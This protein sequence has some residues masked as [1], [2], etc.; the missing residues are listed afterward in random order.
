MAKSLHEQIEWWKR[1]HCLTGPGC[2]LESEVPG[3]ID[4]VEKLLAENVKL[5]ESLLEALEWNWLDKDFNEA[6]FDT[7]T[8][9]A[10]CAI[11]VQTR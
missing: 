11:S 7:F 3:F 4:T 5:A 2:Q 1:Q 6:M 9:Q 8:T 10:E